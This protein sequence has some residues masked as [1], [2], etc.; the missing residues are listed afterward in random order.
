[1][2]MLYGRKV[3]TVLLFLIFGSALLFA[4]NSKKFDVESGMVIYNINGAGKLTN[5]INLTIKGEGKLRFKDWGVVALVEENYEELTTGAIHNLNKV[6]LCKKFEDKQRLDVDFTTGKILERPMPKGN[7]KD[8]YLKGLVKTGQEEVAGYTCDVWE[9]KGVKKCLYKGIPLLSENYLWGIYYQK[10][11]VEV[12]LNIKTSPSKC[13]MPDYPVEKFALFKTHIKTKSVKLPNE[14]ASIIVR[15]SKEMR[16]SLKENKLLE[17]ELSDQQKQPWL[18]KLGQNIY[19]KQMI[20]LPKILLSMKEARICLQ[21]VENVKEA[22]A[23]ISE[24]IN[25][26]KQISS[27]IDNS[28]E[29]W[30]EEGKGKVLDDLDDTIALLE[31]KMK[32]IRGTKKLSDLSNCMK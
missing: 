9:G 24:V 3:K 6:Q 20:F 31:S 26:K 5:D 4:S 22:N 13:V 25:M 17:D 30:D 23:C 1:M 7:F 11:A 19:E 18:D 12:K 32:C 21:Q 28:I 10:K 2:R 29:S 16:K 27:N 14:L 8:Y 15:V